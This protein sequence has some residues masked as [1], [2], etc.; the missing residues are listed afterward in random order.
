MK[1]YIDNVV[2]LCWQ[3]FMM[4]FFFY[5]RSIL[6]ESGVSLCLEL[7]F[8]WNGTILLITAFDLKINSSS[9]GFAA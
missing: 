2:N 3:N 8:N 4:Q 9:G 5:L 7:H 1:Q 6:V